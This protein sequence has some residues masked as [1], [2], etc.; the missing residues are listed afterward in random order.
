MTHGL[1]SGGPQPQGLSPPPSSRPILQLYGTPAGELT[2]IE[3]AAS[4][5]PG[6]GGESPSTGSDGAGKP[7]NDEYTLPCL[8]NSCAT[9]KAHSVLEMSDKPFQ[10]ALGLMQYAIDGLC[11]SPERKLVKV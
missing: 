4:T 2:R 7:E 11:A 5:P 1:S 8:P 6:Q 10:Q 3:P 9:V